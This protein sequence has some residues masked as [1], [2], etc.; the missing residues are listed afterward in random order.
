MIFGGEHD[1]YQERYSSYEDALEGHQVALNLVN[2]LMEK[3]FIYPGFLTSEAITFFGDKRKSEERDEC[4]VVGTFIELENGKTRMPSK[5]D[6]F[7]K[8]ENGN[9]NLINR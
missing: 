4:A 6:I 7:I 1:Q 9:I 5:G 3:E 2:K 8:D